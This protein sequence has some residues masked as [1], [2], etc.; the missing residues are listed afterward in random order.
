MKLGI[1][2]IKRLQLFGDS[3]HQKSL[4][5]Y[6]GTAIGFVEVLSTKLN[7]KCLNDKNYLKYLHHHYSTI[8]FKENLNELGE[9]R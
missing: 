7:A 2:S 6:L 1:A 4:F 8:C 9:P 5:L 3:V